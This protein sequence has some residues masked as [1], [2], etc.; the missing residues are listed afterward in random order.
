MVYRY[1]KHDLPLIRLAFPYP[2]PDVGA[3][4]T[5][6]D[7]VHWMVECVAGVKDEEDAEVLGQLL[8][9]EGAIFHSEGSA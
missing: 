7:I 2:L 8:L 4:F 6:A 9:D 1:L 5:G 3:L